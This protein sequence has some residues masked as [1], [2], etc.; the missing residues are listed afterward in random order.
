MESKEVMRLYTEL[1][2]TK[3]HS[4]PKTGKVKVCE[5]QGVYIIYIQE[6]KV[7]HFGKTYKDINTMVY[8]LYG[9]NEE[10]IRIV[11]QS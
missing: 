8:G 3:T 9:L 2:D 5:E 1:L 6:K 10:E 4:F 7:L 11:E